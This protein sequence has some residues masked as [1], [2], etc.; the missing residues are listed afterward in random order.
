MSAEYHYAE[1]LSCGH[2][3]EVTTFV[4]VPEES[5]LGE[6]SVCY[7]CEPRSFPTVTGWRTMEPWEWQA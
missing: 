1:S 2:F 7:L 6:L 3:L 5:R 4:P